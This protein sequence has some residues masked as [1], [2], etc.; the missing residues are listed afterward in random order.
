MDQG[1]RALDGFKDRAARWSNSDGAVDEV[2][3]EPVDED[4]DEPVDDQP[5]DEEDEPVDEEDEAVDEED[6]AVDEEDEGEPQRK[7]GH[8]KPTR[9][10]PRHRVGS[11]ASAARE[12]GRAD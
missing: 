3:D 8:R 2:E 12:R 5:V 4:E 1:R 10:R 11:L 6:E 7:S 9:S